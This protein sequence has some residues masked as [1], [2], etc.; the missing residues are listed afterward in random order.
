MK[1]KSRP[2]NGQ[3]ESLAGLNRQY[4]QKLEELSQLASR[5]CYEV[6]DLLDR[7]DRSKPVFQRMLS[8]VRTREANL[9]DE[10]RRGSD[11]ATRS[12]RMVEEY[13]R[14]HELGVGIIQ[15]HGLL[16]K[17]SD[18]RTNFTDKTTVKASPLGRDVREFVTGP[19]S[20]SRIN[21]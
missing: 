9:K 10:V 14:L 18:Q 7:V 5:K 13:R 1:N 3:N 16:G 21:N 12:E 19:G 11:R 15:K 6:D 20:S 8:K 17:F 4:K 2:G